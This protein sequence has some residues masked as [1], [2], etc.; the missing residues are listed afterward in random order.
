VEANASSAEIE[1][2]I[3]HTDQVAEIHNTLRTG[4]PVTRCR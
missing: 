1:A 2:L 3:Q 4:V